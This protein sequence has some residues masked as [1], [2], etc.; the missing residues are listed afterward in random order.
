MKSDIEV[1]DDVFLALQSSPIMGEAN[2]ELCKQGV[3]LKDSDKE[4]VVISV[5]ANV[6]ED[7]QEVVVNIN[8]YV[9]DLFVNGQYEENTP[10]LRTLCSVCKKTLKV[11][12]GEDYRMT[13]ISQRVKSVK[14]APVHV[15][16]NSMSYKYLNE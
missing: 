5:V 8:V 2:G 15:I 4:D 9:K 16:N 7:I 3:R 11:V 1:K 14:D 10:R 12:N 6:N 13:L